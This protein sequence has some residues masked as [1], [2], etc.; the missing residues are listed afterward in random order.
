MKKFLAAAALSLFLVPSSAFAIF[1]AEIYGGYSLGSNILDVSPESKTGFGYGLRAH[2]YSTVSVIGYGI[3]GFAQYSPLEYEYDTGGTTVSA[4]FDRA[5]Y[6]A[7]LFLVVNIPLFPLHPYARGGSAVYDKVTT[8]YTLGGQNYKSSD[9]EYFGMYYGGL[10]LGLTVLPIP[11]ID[12]MVFLEYLYEYSK[13]AKNN[14]INLGALVR[15]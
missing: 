1:N 7:D 4:A 9:D 11:A 12:V 3:G 15:L 8:E 10:G 5:S 6:G 2:Y 14:R 13:D